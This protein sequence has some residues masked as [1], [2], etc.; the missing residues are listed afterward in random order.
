MKY[1]GTA[2]SAA[3][4]NDL[5]KYTYNWTRRDKKGVELDTA[6]DY[7]SGKAIFLDSS[8]VNGKMIFGCEVVDDSE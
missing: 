5:P 2:W 1:N 3:T 4:G 8:V 6:S 7:A